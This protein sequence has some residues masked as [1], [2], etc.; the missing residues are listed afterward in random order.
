MLPDRVGACVVALDPIIQALWAHVLSAERIRADDSTVPVIAASELPFVSLV[1]SS[2]G[3]TVGGLFKGFIDLADISLDAG[4]VQWLVNHV[5]GLVG[6]AA[7]GGNIGLYYNS[8]MSWGQTEQTSF[9]GAS[10]VDVSQP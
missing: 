6:G 10:T 3:L 8:R 5:Q 2:H 1:G 7:G 4:R 9:A